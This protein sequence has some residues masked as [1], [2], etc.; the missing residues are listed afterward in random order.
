MPGFFRFFTLKS[1]IDFFEQ[2]ASEARHL[3]VK[4]VCQQA[5]LAD[6][7]GHQIMT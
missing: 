1:G 7:Y 4:M 5:E 3:P 2:L 6:I